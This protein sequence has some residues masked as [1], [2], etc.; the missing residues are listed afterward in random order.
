[1]VYGPEASFQA[2]ELVVVW[3]AGGSGA[4]TP[5]FPF[6]I[7]SSSRVLCVLNLL[8]EGEFLRARQDTVV[9]FKM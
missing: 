6:I 8:P 5:L 2:G 4:G 3:E 1:M 7:H 9:W